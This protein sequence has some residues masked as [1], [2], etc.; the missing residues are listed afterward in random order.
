MGTEISKGLA[1]KV[2][3]GHPDLSGSDKQVAMAIVDRF[4][5]ET[6]RCDPSIQR[7][8]LDTGL[9]VRTVTRATKKAARTWSDLEG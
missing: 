9:I 7:L 8:C 2:I 5:R 6:G 3:C 4:N 1:Y